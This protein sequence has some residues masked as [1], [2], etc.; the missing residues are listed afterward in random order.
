MPEYE[1]WK[2]ALNNNLRG[3]SIKYYKGLGTSTSKEAK[4]YFAG[5]ATHKK[6]FVW[7]G[8]LPSAPHTPARC[9]EVFI[10]V[11]AAIERTATCILLCLSFLYLQWIMLAQMLQ[12][13]C[14][15]RSLNL[16]GSRRQ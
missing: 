7:E 4:E 6:R 12:F 8:A 15:A 9:C 16:G 11:L 5:L 14:Y 13:S 2:D 3:W 10:R 1:N